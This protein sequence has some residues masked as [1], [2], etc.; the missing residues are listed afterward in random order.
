MAAI[1]D[2]SSMTST[3]AMT[4]WSVLAC[5]LGWAPLLFIMHQTHKSIPMWPIIN[6]MYNINIMWDGAIPDPVTLK[7]YSL[8]YV[9]SMNEYRTGVGHSPRA[10]HMFYKLF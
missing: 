10:E 9:S 7:T 3:R 1:G 4:L 6:L 5:N 8:M 2:P